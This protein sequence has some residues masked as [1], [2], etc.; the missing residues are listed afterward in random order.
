MISQDVIKQAQSIDLYEYLATTE[1][2]NIKPEGQYGRLKDNHKIVF[3][4]GSPYFYDNDSGSSG[5]PIDFLMHYRGLSF[6]Q[7]IEALVGGTYIPGVVSNTAPG[8]SNNSEKE[9]KREFTL[10]PW[11]L[12]KEGR[13]NRAFAY[14]TQSR[15]IPAEV[16]SALMKAKK[17][18]EDTNHNCGF[19]D[20]EEQVYEYRSTLTQTREGQKPFRGVYRANKDRYW[21][22]YMGEGAPDAICITEAAIDAIS[23]YVLLGQP[24]NFMF[25]SMAGCCNQ[26]IIDRLKLEGIPLI[27]ATDNDEDGRKVYERNPDIQFC[28]IPRNKDFNE[29]LLEKIRTDKS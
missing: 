19:Y 9:E 25:A 10:E 13:Y 28:Y 18:Y 5:N 16:V 17:L 12:P 14:L 21:S 24:K 29:D 20:A 27:L 26:A 2:G 11:M 6:T 22:F 3:K 15:G 7:A 8:A 23:L 1:P 4:K